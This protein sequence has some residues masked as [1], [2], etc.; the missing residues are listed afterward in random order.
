MSDTVKA[1]GMKVKRVEI[2]GVG[3]AYEDRGRGE[4]PWVL[5]HGYTG[6]W[7]D[8]EGAVPEL[9]RDRRVLLPDLP[10]HGASD[11]LPAG[12]YGLDR[13][14]TLLGQWLDAVGAT[15]CHL[16]GHSMGGMIAMRMAVERP[17]RLASLVLMDTAHEPL[18]WI[19]L[20]LL[21]LAARIGR[22][23]GMEAL[24]KILRTRASDDPERTPADR[25]VEAEWGEARFWEW[26]DRRIEAMDP[27]AYAEL[28]RAM[29]EAP[30]FAERLQ[31]I[32]IP[33]LVMVGAEDEPFLGPS[34]AM[35]ERIP[36]ARQIVVP[37]AA[38]QPQNENPSAWLAAL[39]AHLAAST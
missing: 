24:A 9:A 33:T 10:G 14:A 22:E 26:R 23:A 11:R 20:D 34:R 39:R 2:D 37:D 38:H 18:A 25:R 1:G 35:A 12:D 3:I 7:Q 27:E 16:V 32:T 31:A 15:P 5:V 17:D 4:P 13:L 30:S 28:G 19:Q 6:F 29:A 8:F 36:G 21:E